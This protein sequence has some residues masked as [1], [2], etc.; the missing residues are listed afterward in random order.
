MYNSQ[1]WIRKTL[2]ALLDQSLR[3]MEIIVVDDGSTDMSSNIVKEFRDI[4]LL[5]NPF[6]KGANY[7][8]SWGFKHSKAPFVAFLDSDDLWHSD[9]LQLLARIFA[10]NPFLPAAVAERRPF[11]SANEKLF[12]AS[13]F[14]P[15][16]FQPWD[17]FPFTGIDTPSVMVMRRQA[18]EAIG[19]LPTQFGEIFENHIALKLSALKP[20]IKN[21][22][23]TV[24]RR[25]HKQQL[26]TKLRLSDPEGYFKHLLASLKNAVEYRLTYQQDDS[27]KL[28][29]RL[30]ILELILRILQTVISLNRHTLE[31]YSQKLKT[32]TSEQP[33]SFIKK[34]YESLAWWI[35]PVLYRQELENQRSCAKVLLNNWPE[36]AE[37]SRRMVFNCLPGLRDNLST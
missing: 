27:D 33:K 30:D 11:Y 37:D 36:E 15:V 14:M 4:I 1:A 20:L 3:P 28:R 22:S 5:R 18:F 35:L 25:I 24:A 10:E 12:Q 26:S 17:S 31:I 2:E 8:R 6:K 21:Q 16:V 9:H 7:A 19:K 29:K 23:I 13:A 32:H 34:A